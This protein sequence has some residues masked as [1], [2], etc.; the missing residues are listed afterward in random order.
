MANYSAFNHV[1]YSLHSEKKLN[2]DFE[3]LN[4]Q[5]EIVVYEIQKDLERRKKYEKN[6]FVVTNDAC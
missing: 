5:W 4:L 3:K 6:N 2:Y 1:P